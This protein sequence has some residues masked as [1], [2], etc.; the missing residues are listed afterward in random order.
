MLRGLFS[1]AVGTTAS[2]ENLVASSGFCGDVATV[3]VALLSP[4]A[5]PSNE[6]TPL[7]IDIA[8]DEVA[9]PPLE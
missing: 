9:F 1:L 4:V 3:N 6:N 2:A 7:A 5:E 8:P